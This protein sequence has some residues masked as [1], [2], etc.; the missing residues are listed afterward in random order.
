MKTSN[1]NPQ[2]LLSVEEAK[3]KIL[4]QILP[5]GIEKIALP[6]ARNR[7]VAQNIS[8]KVNLPAFDNSAMDGYAVQ[9]N[10]LVQ[11]TEQ[12]PVVL[13]VVGAVRAGEIYQGPPM[14]S[15]QAI[16]IMTGGMIPAGADAVVMREWT[17]E[18]S[19]IQVKNPDGTEVTSGKVSV[20]QSASS[21]THVRKCGEDVAIH[22]IILRAGDVMT[23]A[24]IGLCAAAMHVMIPVYR[25]PV[26]AIVASGDELRDL[27]EPVEIG[28]L[29][30]SNAYSIAAA[31]EDAG[32]IAHIVGIAKDTLEDHQKLIEAASFADVLL[33][34]GGVSVGTHDFT[35]DALAQAG[36]SLQMWRVAMRPGKPI[37]FGKRERAASSLSQPQW[38]F[39]LPGNPVSSLVSFTLFV[40]PALHML[41]GRPATTIPATTSLLATLLDKNGFQKKAGLTLFARAIVQQIDGAWCVRTLDKQGSA[42]MSAMAQA[43]ALC[44]FDAAQEKIAEG[45]QVPVLLLGDVVVNSHTENI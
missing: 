19:V 34:I 27:G 1:P 7:V 33:T 41:Q 45:T 38:V 29:V 14:S 13:D 11:A 18:A 10:D 23:P 12:N 28:Q 5:L 31:V 39:G 36:V 6:Q 24:R 43:N 3:Q 26:V 17:H 2:S 32:G 21:G 16:R 35:K 20:W 30:N 44:I 8:S 37:A 15:G 40:L 4:S 9:S 25:R 22:E 42:H